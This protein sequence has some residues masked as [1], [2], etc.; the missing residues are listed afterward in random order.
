MAD[1][2]NTPSLTAEQARAVL[3]YEPETGRLFWRERPQETFASDWAWKVWNMRWAGA[4]AMTAL[5]SKGYRSG[6]IWSNIHRAH[7]VIWLMQTGEW[8]EDQID[9]INGVRTDNRWG[10][11][12]EVTNTENGR[13]QKKHV[14]NTTGHTGVY[15]EPDRKKWAASVNIRG[16]NKRLGRFDTIDAAVAAREAANKKFGFSD[17]HGR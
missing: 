7:R 4:E 2:P 9:H 12:R 11:L 16:R 10:N 17:R 14:T 1:E 15:W 13:N 8:P 3:R 5:N 6:K